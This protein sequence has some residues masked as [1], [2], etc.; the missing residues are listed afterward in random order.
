MVVLFAITLFVSAGLLFAVQPMVGK[1]ILPSFGGT[2]AVWNTCMVFFQAVL[3]AG[4]LYAHGA[5]SWLGV[6]RQTVLH[7]LVMLGPLA[8]LPI[9]LA[10]G[11]PPAADASPV[12]WLLWRLTAVAGLPIFV[13]SATAPLLQKWF[14]QT[15]HPSAHDPYF[16]YGASNLGSLAALLGY[17]LLIEPG[18]ALP[19]QTGS[20][21]WG[22]YGLVALVAMCA[23]VVRRS[24][25]GPA[26]DRDSSVPIESAPSASR[27]V[28]WI[29]CAA[30]PSSLLLGVTTHITTNI[31]AV[32]LLWVLPLALYL[33]TFI[34]AFERRPILPHR[35]MIRLFPFVLPVLAPLIFFESPHL[36][37]L[38]IPLH[39]LIFF[40]VAMVC[41]G[42]LMRTRPATQHLTAFYLWMSFGG[43]LGGMFNAV[44]APFLFDSIVEYPLI[45]AAAC[46]LLPAV[47]SN[48]KVRAD[49]RWTDV[50]GEYRR[51]TASSTTSANRLDVALPAILAGLCAVII[52]AFRRT[53]WNSTWLS[54]GILIVIGAMTCFAFKD[55]PLRFALGFSVYLAA[56][57]VYSHIPT[58]A[59]LHEERNFFG[60]KRVFVTREG[61]LRKFVH[62][63]TNHGMQWND[64]ARRSEPTA[65]Y[66]RAG[67]V[68]DVFRA[69][70]PVTGLNRVGIVGLGAGAMATYVEPEQHFTFYEID[71]SVARIARD[72]KLF[73][74]LSDCRGKVDVVL[75]DGRLTLGDSPNGAFDL[76]M[77]DAFS[78]DSVPTHLLSREALAMYVDK[79]TRD[80]A[81][82]FHISNGYLDLE[83]VM[84]RLAGDAGL[85]A[86]H[87]QDHVVGG[88]EH[89]DARMS[90][91]FV[92]MARKEADLG[93][94][95]GLATWPHLADEPG[96]PLWTDQYCNIVDLFLS[97]RRPTHRDG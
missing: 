52:W 90:S 50:G 58:G 97:P 41:H 14:A 30:V 25:S 16:L 38:S 12:G 89:D 26:R 95:T 71:P 29:L 59:L 39:L 82:V 2:P 13:V 27:R 11:G 93:E 85:V 34:L 33:V 70:R 24:P 47:V 32:P 10:A 88:V 49:V 55:R 23:F 53:S 20:W 22:Y 81:I 56:I 57:G 65:Y 76:I 46:F 37:W 31:A 42:E 61:D 36:T 67:P 78:S 35:V 83:P 18:L 73:T 43:V 75:G 94:L 91:H 48:G 68:G 87:R 9:V 63:T 84:A 86:L 8:L 7:L 6:R 79:L 60:V 92:I 3:L 19:A 54:V 44:A 62:G 40:A 45:L 66:H 80:G 4:Y 15:G 21:A 28:R 72:P 77:L 96:A 17:P 69:L 1:M 51:R 5:V 74:F 64:P